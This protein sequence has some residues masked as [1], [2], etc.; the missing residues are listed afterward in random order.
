MK[1]LSQMDLESLRY[2]E[3]TSRRARRNPLLA[4][5]HFY[6][7]RTQER[8]KLRRYTQ[9][10]ESIQRAADAHAMSEDAEL[11][12]EI[13]LLRNAFLNPEQAASDDMRGRALALLSELA[14]R[15]VGQ[16]PYHVQLMAALAM[17]DEHVV[18]L[19]P[20]E[21]KTLTLSLVAT[22]FAWSG[23]PC[24]VVTA[25]D[26]LAARDA[27]DM[28]PLYARCRLSV[29][30]VD[31]SV[32]PDAK[33]QR[34]AADVVY[35]TSKQLLADYLQDTL[36]AGGTLDRLSLVLKEITQRAYQPMMRGLHTAIIDEADSILVDEATV[37]LIISEARPEPLLVAGVEAAREA[38]KV[39]QPQRH[40][41]I[42]RVFRDVIFNSAGKALVDA[43]AD[44]LPALWQHP[45]R[46]EDILKQAILARDYYQRDVHY[47]VDDEKVVIVDES[48]GRVM[49]GRS[50][51]GGL[52]QAIE[53]KEGVPITDP[54][55]TRARM[56]FQNFF[57][58]FHRLCGA[59][60]TLQ[61]IESEIFIEYR[62]AT[63]RI[64]S[65]LPSQLAVNSWRA[66]TNKTRKWAHLMGLIEELHAASRPVLVG[67]RN[68][69]D[70]ER[71]AVAMQERG[72][73]FS[74]LNA[75]HH[76]HEAAIVA[77]AGE[78]GRITI[79]TNMAGRGTDIKVSAACLEA[80]GLVVVMVEPHESARVDWQ[81][82]GR[83][84]RQGQ[85]GM[86]IPLVALDDELIRLHLPAWWLP[87]KV[88]GRI[89]PGMLINQVV[90]AAQKSAQKKAFRHRQR[91]NKLDIKSRE[92]M[93]FAK[94]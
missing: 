13:A 57:K 89:F 14:W 6:Y 64:P 81:L 3:P 19:A 20:G 93:S 30:T 88:V 82:F 5:M 4:R 47:L 77:T 78:P 75:K 36:K 46:T 37:P 70:S 35:S 94:S 51:S 21:G 28:Q 62:R 50:W 63:L 26:Y 42:D 48:T 11:D 59:T 76:E 90:R 7:V 67:T 29:T 25:N 39:L 73:P 8:A 24:C 23:K 80:G 52:H 27:E 45:E 22:L 16:R 18:Q 56:S 17:L 68:V 58:L 65:R 9:A 10:A 74:L 54:N 43:A 15:E 86:V 44:E 60:G 34:Y 61:N 91:L 49:P 38:I 12:A 53:L 83:A 41:T 33:R 32:E 84:G 1:T 31:G 40:Y 87:V 69:V 72:L 66:Y 92:A 79:A 71:L 55:I 2:L 85:P